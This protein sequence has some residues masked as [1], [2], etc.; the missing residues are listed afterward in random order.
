MGHPFQ[1][2]VDID[3]E[4]QAYL[5]SFWTSPRSAAKRAF[6]RRLFDHAQAGADALDACA[7]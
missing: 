6:M 3:G 4:P 5:D 1:L 7:A 2:R